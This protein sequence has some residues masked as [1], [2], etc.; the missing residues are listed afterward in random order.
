MARR[1]LGLAAQSERR[2][3]PRAE[4]EVGDG[5]PLLGD[6]RHDA[7]ARALGDRLAPGPLA[8]EGAR[9]PGSHPLDVDPDVTLRR[10]RDQRQPLGM[11]EVEAEPGRAASLGLPCGPRVSSSSGRVPPL[12]GERQPQRPRAATQRPPPP[13]TWI[14]S[15][16]AARSGGSASS[17]VHPFPIQPGPPHVDLA[18]RRSGPQRSGRPAHGQIIVEPAIASG[19]WMPASGLAG[20]AHLQR[21]GQHRGARRGGVWRSCRPRAGCWSSTTT[22]PTGPARSPRGSRSGSERV[23]VLRRPRKEGLGPAYVAGFRRA[24]DGRRGAGARDGRRL[25]PRP[26]LPA[27]AARGGR[28]RRPGDRLALRRRRRR[29]GLERAAAGDQPR[30][31]RLRPRSPSGSRSAT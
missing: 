30:R 11:A 9:V 31:Q 8:V 15:R 22:R 25:L 6:G 18:I 5:D 23:E 1:G 3:P 26:R 28:A 29:L 12:A 13:S 20:A 16:A 19:R 27:A 21:G 7:R 2:R 10:D 14:S 24:L 17:S 4:V